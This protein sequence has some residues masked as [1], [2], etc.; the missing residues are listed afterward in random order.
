MIED[1]TKNTQTTPASSG[2]SSG[3]ANLKPFPKGVSGNPKGQPKGWKSLKS[4]FEDNL[5]IVSASNEKT[6]ETYTRAEMIIKKVSK[7][8]EEGNLKA[9]EI[10]FDRLE[11]KATQKQEITGKDGE[12]VE[13]KT[14]DMVKSADFESKWL[15]AIAENK[16]NNGDYK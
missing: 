9:V 8:A 15:K 1:N 7:M 4:L 11:G 12:A 14:Y 2:K 10:M 6:G 16:E 3:I 13:I 5:K